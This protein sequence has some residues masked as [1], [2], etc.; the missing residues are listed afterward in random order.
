MTESPSWR[1]PLALPHS[2][3][4]EYFPGLLV[5][6]CTGSRTTQAIPAERHG[7]TSQG[8][9]NCYTVSIKKIDFHSMAQDY[10]NSNGQATRHYVTTKRGSYH[11]TW[12]P[13]P[14]TNSRFG[15]EKGDT[16]GYFRER[17]MEARDTPTITGR[18]LPPRSNGRPAPA[19]ANGIDSRRRC[20]TC[21]PLL[22]DVYPH[23]DGGPFPTAASSF[24]SKFL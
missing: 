17:T 18:S 9:G 20:V 21:T 4:I 15:I 22:K 7:S 10:S 24:P 3:N 13:F 2:P 14:S 23:R 1:S 8:R 19:L 6:T 12:I 11:S 16:G 5:L